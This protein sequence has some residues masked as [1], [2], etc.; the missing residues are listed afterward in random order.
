[1]QSS[2]VVRAAAPRA[3]QQPGQLTGWKTTTLTFCHIS[4]NSDNTYPE[5]T[6]RRKSPKNLFEQKL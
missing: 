5:F 4:K 6:A 3:R 2:A 1:M